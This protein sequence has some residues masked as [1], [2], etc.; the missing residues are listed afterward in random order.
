LAAPSTRASP[1]SQIFKS[2]LAFKSRLLGFKSRCN[3]FALWMYFKP[4]KS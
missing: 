3:T 4:R 1:K 2:Q